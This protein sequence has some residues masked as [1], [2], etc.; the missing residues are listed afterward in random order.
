MPGP[1]AERLFASGMRLSP[2]SFYHSSKCSSRCRR[3]SLWKV[4]SVG[5]A[6]KKQERLPGR[7]QDVD[8]NGDSFRHAFGMRRLL[9]SFCVQMEL[10]PQ[11]ACS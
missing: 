4:R 11:L 1:M 10:R 2:E 9:A 3:T 6:D 8:V 5:S 7:S